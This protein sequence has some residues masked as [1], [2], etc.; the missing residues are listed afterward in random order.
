MKIAIWWEQESWGGVDT[1]ILTLLKYWSKSDELFLFSNIGNLGM[2]RI[3]DDL[4]KISNLSVINYRSHFTNKNKYSSVN[5]CKSMLRPFLFLQSIYQYTKLLNKY[6]DFDVMLSE[7]GGYPAS[8]GCLAVIVSAKKCGINKRVLLVHHEAT[9][10]RFFQKYFENYIDHVVGKIST[11]I[12]AVSLATR[13]S[14]YK[15]RY[16]LT[17]KNPVRVVY[18]GVEMIKPSSTLFNLRDKYK[19]SED[20]KLIG[21]V[22]RVE[23]YKGHED[24]IF[25]YSLLNKAEQKNIQLIFIGSG[26]KLEIDRL[27]KIQNSLECENSIIFTGYLEGEVKSIIEQLDM[28]CVVTKDF[29]GFGLTIAEAMLCNVPVLTTKVG[30]IPEF[31]FDEIASIVNPESPHQIYNYLAEFTKDSKLFKKKADI[32]SKYIQKFSPERMVNHLK[33]IF[34]N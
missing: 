31:V 2:D 22:G 23:R 17:K 20:K 25:A 28:L 30:A 4:L 13:D 9:R 14:L 3:S 27:I 11:D 10:P 24:L 21:V 1:H 16:F 6:G 15:Y 19:I 12:V 32:A 26:D 7:N 33:Y 5:K 34:N 8:W 18:N 29:E